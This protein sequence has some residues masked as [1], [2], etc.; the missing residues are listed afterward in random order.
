MIN[1]YN[2]EGYLFEKMTND[3]QF[4]ILHNLS[5]THTRSSTRCRLRQTLSKYSTIGETTIGLSTLRNHLN[6]EK[7]EK[8]MMHNQP[9]SLI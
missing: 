8:R 5:L 2:L 6:L 7:R 3:L 1:M 9:S 4:G